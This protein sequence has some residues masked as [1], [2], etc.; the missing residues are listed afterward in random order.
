MPCKMDLPHPQLHGL[1]VLVLHLAG[2]YQEG[3]NPLCHH[4]ADHC[5]GG[6]VPKGP[7]LAKR[8]AGSGDR[9]SKH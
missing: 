1:S 8:V 2:P 9:A 7:V 5:L 4:L 3:P 6:Q